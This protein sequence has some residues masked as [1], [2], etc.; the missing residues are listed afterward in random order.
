MQDQ[1]VARRLIGR[2]TG[3]AVQSLTVSPLET[4]DAPKHD[5]PLTGV[6]GVQSCAEGG[7]RHP[8]VP[9]N[10]PAHAAVFCVDEKT[11]IQ[12]LHRNDPVLPLSPGRP[13]R[14]RIHS[15]YATGKDAYGAASREVGGGRSPR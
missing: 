14:R 5:L 10:P 3:L 13:A 1:R 7:R 4:V 8:A 11:A 2:I 15:G 12:A 9:E 6:D